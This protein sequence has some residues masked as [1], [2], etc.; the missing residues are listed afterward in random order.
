MFIIWLGVIL[1]VESWFCF[2]FI[3]SQIIVYSLNSFVCLELHRVVH[4]ERLA[5]LMEVCKM[6]KNRH[7]LYIFLFV[8]FVSGVFGCV[9]S[10]TSTNSSQSSIQSFSFLNLYST[11]NK[12]LAFASS[13]R[14][15]SRIVRRSSKDTRQVTISNVSYLFI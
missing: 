13:I 8:I 4:T 1:G 9:W 2:F 10:C 3:I 6:T 15:A 11:T 7:Y 12:K 5:L 14:S